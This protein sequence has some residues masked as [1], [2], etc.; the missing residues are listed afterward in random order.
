MLLLLSKA[1]AAD[2]RRMGCTGVDEEADQEEE[3]TAAASSAIAAERD[4]DDSKQSRGM[5]EGR[6]KRCRL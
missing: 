3:E 6:N 5:K 4:K 2:V 1:A